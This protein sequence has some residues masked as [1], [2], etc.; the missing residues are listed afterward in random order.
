MTCGSA[1]RGAVQ[2]SGSAQVRPTLNRTRSEWWWFVCR[3]GRWGWWGWFGDGV[4]LAVVAVSVGGGPDVDAAVVFDGPAGFVLESVM[5]P[6]E[7]FEVFFAGRPVRVCVAVV[8]VAGVGR[9]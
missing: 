5:V 7:T 2:S 3:H 9:A 8:D 4:G 1:V 6:A